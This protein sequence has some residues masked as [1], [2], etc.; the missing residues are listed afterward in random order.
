MSERFNQHS[1]AWVAFSYFTF[2]FACGMVAAGVA[3]LPIEIWSKG[4]LLMGMAMLVQAAINVTK[5]IRDNYESE[6]LAR[7]L[8]DARTERLLKESGPAGDLV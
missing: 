6:T 4:Y 8:E 1:R 3:I 7:R 5:T 2:V